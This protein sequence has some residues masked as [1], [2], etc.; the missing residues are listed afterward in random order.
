MDNITENKGPNQ[1][2]ARPVRDG[3]GRPEKMA[4]T[5][6]ESAD[7][8]GLG[9]VVTRNEFYRDGYRLALRVALSSA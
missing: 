1:R 7:V 3:A 6:P 4:T 2:N 9:R 5:R 8:S